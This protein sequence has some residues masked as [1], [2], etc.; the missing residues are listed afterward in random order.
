[1]KHV[2]VA[3]IAITTGLYGCKPA[4]IATPKV[5]KLVIAQIA[6]DCYG[7]NC[8]TTYSINEQDLMKEDTAHYLSSIVPYTFAKGVRQTDERHQIAVPLMAQVPKNLA[9]LNRS[10]DFGCT[11]CLGSGK[12]MVELYT[13]GR[14]VRVLLED[15][16]SYDQNDE[17][18]TFRKQIVQTIASLKQ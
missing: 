11:S 9:L 16:D 14:V 5:N 7:N 17:V 13:N 18:R 15:L 6:G 1:M 3:A 8:M 2:A 4:P 12:V 10:H